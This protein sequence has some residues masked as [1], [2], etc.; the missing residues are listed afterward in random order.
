MDVDA[1]HHPIAT[2]RDF[3]IHL[4]TITCGL[5]IALSLEAGVEWMHHRALVREARA[6]IRQEI[7]DNQKA[8]AQDIKSVNQDEARFKINLA[9]ERDLRAHPVQFHGKLQF[10]FEWSSLSD[11]AWKT[12]QDTG[13]F[14]Y[15]P[16][17]EVQQYADIYAQQAI[18]DSTAVQIFRQQTEAFAPLLTEAD[19]DALP[20]DEMARLLHESAVAEI[21]L[22]TLAQMLVEL[23]DQDAKFLSG[24]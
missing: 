8:A 11:S 9:T 5:L 14:A 1:P 19:V 2:K 3:F 20:K 21:D 18:L 4:F 12:A 22:H 23:Q 6:N 17:G 24:K 16:Y 15:M 10:N 7:N 13:A